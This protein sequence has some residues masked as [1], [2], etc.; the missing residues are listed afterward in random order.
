[1]KKL[2]EE[3]SQF[4]N[5]SLSLGKAGLIILEKQK[6]YAANLKKLE[7]TLSNLGYKKS[8]DYV[9]L[10]DDLS[11]GKNRIFYVE[12]DK[13]LDGFALEIIAEFEAG[14]VSLADR[15]NKSGL[16]TATWNPLKT[17]MII[18]MARKQI[19]NSY[20]RLFEYINLT[21]SI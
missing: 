13:K 8:N 2:Q 10:M 5:A 12:H 3:I 17:S 11:S 15:K 19:E 7:K 14:I 18:V 16:K 9:D 20:P 21:K 1:M 6:D 4:S